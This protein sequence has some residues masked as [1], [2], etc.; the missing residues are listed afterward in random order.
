[1]I[2]NVIKIAFSYMYIKLKFYQFGV[3]IFQN[4]SNEFRYC[5]IDDVML[6]N[7][8]NMNT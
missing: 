6:M 2:W 7:I 8:I 1:M 5:V 3:S 4:L